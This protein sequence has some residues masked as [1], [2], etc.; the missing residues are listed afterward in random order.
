[1]AGR[2]G[3]GIC[4]YT[5]C[6]KSCGNAAALGNH[7]KACVFG[8]KLD[9]GDGGGGGGGVDEDDDGEESRPYPIPDLKI[10]DTLL[11]RN[12]LTPEQ[13]LEVEQCAGVLEVTAN[14]AGAFARTIKIMDGGIQVTATRDSDGTD[15]RLSFEFSKI[16]HADITDYSVDC[17]SKDDFKIELKRAMLRKR[18]WRTE[19]PFTI[20]SI[21]VDRGAI[22]QVG[23][24]RLDGPNIFLA[25]EYMCSWIHDGGDDEGADMEVE[26]GDEGD[27]QAPKVN[28][29]IRI[30]NSV[31][32]AYGK[33]FKVASISQDI[34]RLQNVESNEFSTLPDGA[35]WKPSAYP[36]SDTE[37]EE[38]DDEEEGGE[39]KDGEEEDDEEEDDEEDQSPPVVG[40][41]V[42]IGDVDGSDGLSPDAYKVIK[43]NRK[44]FL[45]E[46][47][48]N[49]ISVKIEKDRW[50]IVESPEGA[51]PS[52]N[53][54]EKPNTVPKASKAAS[55]SSGGLPLL[56]QLV[57]DAKCKI[58]ELDAGLTS[59]RTTFISKRRAELDAEID[60]LLSDD[61]AKEIAGT[62]YVTARK[63]ALVKYQSS[64]ESDELTAAL[65]S[66]ETKAVELFE[67]ENKLK[68]L[69][70]PAA[71]S[72]SSLSKRKRTPPS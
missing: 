8:K 67:A 60:A 70:K 49:K 10:G 58:M 72:S 17:R 25:S 41:Y 1:M 24:D 35:M 47:A 9:A 48:G 38:E 56:Q 29:Y 57:D 55:S 3:G 44:T 71:G 40:D 42:R 4:K 37:D 65:A 62:N 66:Y 18:P 43:V 27:D 11:E 7:E 6:G 21:L 39:E 5:G 54:P 61:A 69:V 30:F 28:G 36:A 22:V 20:T 13:S 59:Q 64:S 51:E 14:V 46:V 2:T 12:P 45:V 33:P 15:V 50:A 23:I 34:I 26:G 19:A 63:E 68:S 53:T 32:S 52:G 31:T 16:H